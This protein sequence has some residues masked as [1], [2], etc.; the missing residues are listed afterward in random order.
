MSYGTYVPALLAFPEL[1]PNLV[2]VMCQEGA[3]IQILYLSC[4]ILL[5]HSGYIMYT[6]M[7]VLVA[8]QNVLM[9]FFQNLQTFFSWDLF[10]STHISHIYVTIISP[11]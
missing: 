4:L 9:C 1:L 11:L 8:Q 7:S 2:P 5:M 10:Y 3:S 6:A